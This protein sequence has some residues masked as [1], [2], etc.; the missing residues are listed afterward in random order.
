MPF[1]AGDLLTVTAGLCETTDAP[2]KPPMLG[3][4]IIPRLVGLTL[5]IA[6]GAKA[7]APGE[8]FRSLYTVLSMA[9]FGGV[10]QAAVIGLI[11]L[12]VAIGALLVMRPTRPLCWVACSM[13]TTFALY[14]LGLIVMNV[15]VGCG[16]GVALHI[17]GLDD[18]WFSVVRAAVMACAVCPVALQIFSEGAKAQE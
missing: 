6:A 3:I 4:G 13:L 9:H 10:A 18:R 5:L 8:T 15:P 16:C 1:P 12:E 14:A 11:M 2:E 17:P 7:Y